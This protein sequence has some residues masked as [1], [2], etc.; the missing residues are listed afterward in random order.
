MTQGR[1]RRLGPSSPAEARTAG[2]AASA[3]RWANWAS[4]QDRLHK[5]RSPKS[6]FEG[7]LRAHTP[8]VQGRVRHAMRTSTHTQCARLQTSYKPATD[9]LTCAMSTL[10]YRVDS[11]CQMP[12]PNF[13]HMSSTCKGHATN[14]R[15]PQKPAAGST[16]PQQQPRRHEL[17][18]TSVRHA[19]R[20]SAL[21]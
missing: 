19:P 9:Q 17:M 18:A 7:M 11:A 12:A 5:C 6:A 13:C 16:K 1:Q 4:E 10:A 20:P 15:S 3:D 8:H 14:K 21:L 2:V